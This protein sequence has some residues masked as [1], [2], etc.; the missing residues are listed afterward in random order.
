MPVDFALESLI[1]YLEKQGKVAFHKHDAFQEHPVAVKDHQKY[2]AEH[3]V[4]VTQPEEQPKQERPPTRWWELN[5]W[6]PNPWE[7][8]PEERYAGL[9]AEA[10]TDELLQFKKNMRISIQIA[11]QDYSIAKQKVA[12]QKAL[13]VIAKANK[14]AAAYNAAEK[15]KIEFRSLAR[16]YKRELIKHYAY[17][18]QLLAELRKTPIKKLPKLPKLP[19][20]KPL[21]PDSL[22]EEVEQFLR[23]TIPVGSYRIG[24]GA[25]NPDRVVFEDGTS[26]IWK[27]KNKDYHAGG[28]KKEVAAYELSKIIGLSYLVPPTVLKNYDKTTGSLQKWVEETKDWTWGW[29]EKPKVDKNELSDAKLFDM[30]ILNKDRHP[31]NVLLKDGHIVLIDHGG[32]LTDSLYL[33]EGGLFREG[34][35]VKNHKTIL[36]DLIK[37]EQEVRKQLSNLLD[38]REIDSL[39]KRAHKMLKKY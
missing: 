27:A 36:L 37:N 8:R 25:S 12:A 1:V 14:D 4:P 39:F 5:P 28:Y 17:R 24:K 29:E 16:E 33:D 26:G 11:Q 15:D 2:F 19:K 34:F 35:F 21:S 22:Q 30:L 18:K 10:N 38:N 6:E 9:F 3:F 7:L 20:P 13:Q 31:G 23:D 32:T